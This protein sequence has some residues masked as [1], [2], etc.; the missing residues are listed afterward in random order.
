MARTDQ[1]LGVLLH[2]RPR[3]HPSGASAGRLPVSL[4]LSFPPSDSPFISSSTISVAL[5]SRYRVLRSVTQLAF[6]DFRFVALFSSRGR[7]STHL[8]RLN[9]P[10]LLPPNTKE[11]LLICFS[12]SSVSVAVAIVLTV[13]Q[14][15]RPGGQRGRGPRSSCPSL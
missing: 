4:Q 10:P 3:Q 15:E 1:L 14:R 6:A 5:S 12:G 7:K 8:L 11:R 9:P 2:P 13:M